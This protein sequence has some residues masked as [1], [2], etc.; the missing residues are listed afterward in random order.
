[1]TSTHER[2]LAQWMTVILFKCRK[3]ENNHIFKWQSQPTFFLCLFY[4]IMLILFLITLLCIF[5]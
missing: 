1:L 3:L 5:T 4:T 2:T